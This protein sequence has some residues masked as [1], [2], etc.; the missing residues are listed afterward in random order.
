MRAPT[1]PVGRTY[2]PAKRDRVVMGS[3][4]MRST[5]ETGSGSGRANR[6][7]ALG[8]SR[9]G[10]IYRHRVRGAIDHP[11]Y[12]PGLDGLRAISV[13][14]VIVAHGGF[15]H[16]VPGGLG[17]T[18]FFFISGFLITN[19]LIS[20]AVQAGRN[21]IGRFYMRRY[22][23]LTPELS[24][25]ILVC[26]IGSAI[27]FHVEIGR[28]IASA[29][30]FMNY[31]VLFAGAERAVPPNPFVLGHLW[32]LAVEEHFY[33]VFPLL[34]FGL[35]RR[36][37]VF[38]VVLVAIC[39]A[40]IADRAIAVGVFHDV[41][42]TYFASDARI[43]SIIYGCLLALAMRHPLGERV[44]DA[45]GRSPV[46]VAA[47]ALM[48]ATLVFRGETFRDV[49]RYSAQGLA[50]FIGVACLYTS[51]LGAVVV[52]V[53]E[54][55]VLRFIGRISYGMYLWHLLPSQAFFIFRGI[56]P[57]DSATASLAD[58]LGAVVAST[59][60]AIVM[61]YLGQRLLL[62]PLAGLRHRYGSRTAESFA[63]AAG[64]KPEANR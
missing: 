62:R 2:E 38:A 55:S 53:L 49:F 3:G 43:D 17:V 12:I 45:L 39:L 40:A 32:S 57:A 1:N 44:A 18:V 51:V 48:I 26:L 6:F 24:A 9:D 16:I 33:L 5:E 25:Y 52:Q 23:R 31:Y 29:L 21:D 15:E 63:D 14:L 61:G 30:Y 8:F 41:D 46:L 27:F 60:V 19:L 34:F 42:Y 50:L 36:P 28:F 58:K 47:L 64:S 20:E 4:H 56:A 54:T 11:D 35:F 22:L 13:M 10:A 37:R 59:V 7:A